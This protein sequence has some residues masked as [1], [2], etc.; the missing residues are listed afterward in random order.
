MKKK[1]EPYLVVV[2]VKRAEGS[3]TFRVKASSEAD[4]IKRFKS[5]GGE[6][7]EE[8]V[9]VVDLDIDGA[10]VQLESDLDDEKPQYSLS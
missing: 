9:E 7:V 6:F 8:E 4:A 2:Q 1:L 10:E 5:S 3:Q